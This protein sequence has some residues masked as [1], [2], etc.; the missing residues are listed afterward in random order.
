MGSS[1]PVDS[2]VGVRQGD[3]RSGLIFN[4]TIDFILRRTQLEGEGLVNSGMVHHILAYAD[5]VVLLAKY[6]EHLQVLLDLIN[7]MANKI[8]LTFNPAKCVTMHYAC[9]KPSGARNTVFFVE[10]AG[11]PHSNGW[12]SPRV[13]R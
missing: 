2:S 8:G 3:P 5:D 6:R 9:K 13:P 1:A 4:L 11:Y 12:C 10:W 7:S